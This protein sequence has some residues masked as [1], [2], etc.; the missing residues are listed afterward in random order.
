MHA[1]WVNE[2]K[3]SLRNVFIDNPFGL[4]SEKEQKNDKSHSLETA[5]K[6]LTLLLTFR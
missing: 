6:F 1:L 5:R 4:E 2:T 3:V